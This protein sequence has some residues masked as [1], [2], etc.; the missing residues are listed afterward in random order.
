[1]L[2]AV[3]KREVRHRLTT[4]GLFCSAILSI[5]VSLDSN[6]TVKRIAHLLFTC[7]PAQLTADANCCVT[8]M[9]MDAVRS[10]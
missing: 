5:Q 8:T 7:L 6:C 4:V 3:E 10:T 2:R 1:M 9:V